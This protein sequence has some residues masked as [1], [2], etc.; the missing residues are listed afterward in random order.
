MARALLL[1]GI[2][3]ASL[4]Q[5]ACTAHEA[6]SADDETSTRPLSPPLTDQAIAARFPGV[7][8]G[9]AARIT[10]GRRRAAI[11][12]PAFKEG[13]LVDAEVVAVAFDPQGPRWRPRGEPLRVSSPEGPEALRAL[14]GGEWV[15]ERRCGHPRE[16]IP[17][18]V[19]ERL[20]AFRQ[21]HAAGDVDAALQ[22]YTALTT[23]FAF[24]LVAYDDLV[25]H[26]LILA[27]SDDGLDLT[28]TAG[29]NGEWFQ[30]EASAGER[31]HQGA[32]PLVRCADGWVLGKPLAG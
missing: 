8:V 11:V 12:W 13:A 27:T 3:T 7:R 16:A 19:R 17:D 10:A 29:D 6:T 30:V 1:G 22:A 15:V 14:L 18:F 32:M 2:L 20:G 4:L 26:W 24:E 31:R 25:T 23:A 5:P 9:V 21:A 28:F